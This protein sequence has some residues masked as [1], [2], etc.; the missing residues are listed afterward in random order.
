VKLTFDFKRGLQI[1]RQ[2]IDKV[3]LWNTG[4]DIGEPVHAGVT[5]SQESALRLSVVWACIRLIASTLGAL[6]GDIIRKV[7][8]TSQLADRLPTWITQPNPETSWFEFAERCFESLEMDGNAFILIS[9]RDANGFP[10]ELWTLNPR[11][12]DVRRGP[13]NKVFFL[14]A[15]DQ[16]LTKFGPSAPL[17]NVLHIKGL[18]A[19]GLRGMSPIEAA[20]QAIGLG[21]VT[22]KVGARFFG[23]GMVTEW[24]VELPDQGGAAKSR[25][26]VNLMRETLKSHNVGSSKSFDPLIATGGAKFVR[27]TIPPEDAQFLQTRAFQVEDIASRIYGVP[28]HMV[29]LTEKQTSWGT[30]L[31]QQVIGFVRFSLLHRIVRFESAMSSLLPRGQFLKLNQRGLLRADSKTEAEVLQIMLQNSVINPN[32]WRELVDEPPRPGGDQYILPL[33][34]QVLTTRGQTPTPEPSPSGNGQAPAEVTQP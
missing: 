3:N 6:P 25:E 1:E 5:V 23:Q 12:I 20:R 26:Y 31:E 22:E 2:S 34:F 30:G 14:W 15:G 29:G 7:G 10:A 28:P 33:N 18:T 27:F 32:R 9:G 21:L 11:Q 19:G 4:A 17:G 16:M 24:G 13:D 8:Q